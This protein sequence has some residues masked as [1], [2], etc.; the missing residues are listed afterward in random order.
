M[1]LRREEFI[2]VSCDCQM[3]ALPASDEQGGRLPTTWAADEY[4]KGGRVIKPFGSSTSNQQSIYC[5]E[6]CRDHHDGATVSGDVAASLYD[7]FRAGGG[8]LVSGTFQG[9]HKHY[10]RSNTG[11]LLLAQNEGDN[12]VEACRMVRVDG[13]MRVGQDFRQEA[14]NVF[15]K[16]ISMKIMN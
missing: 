8:Y 6:C 16:I 13:F 4:D 11:E 5:D 2:G 12:Y 7:P 14:R 9:D 10:G 3:E 15:R 1:F